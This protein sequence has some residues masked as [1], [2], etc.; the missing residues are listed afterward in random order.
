MPVE[1]ER[2]ARGPSGPPP[3]AARAG[4]II[5]SRR[6]LDTYPPTPLVAI[7]RFAGAD[8]RP[9]RREGISLVRSS[10]RVRYRMRPRSGSRVQ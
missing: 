2:A 9:E 6:R 10:D 3:K 8:W 1:G 4:D 7:G 5:L